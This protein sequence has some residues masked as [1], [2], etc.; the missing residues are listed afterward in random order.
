MSEIND[1]KEIS[2]GTFLVNLKLIANIN[3]HNPDYWININMVRTMKVI[4]VEEVI[5]ILTL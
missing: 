4:F 1:I 5:Y 2:E 3:G